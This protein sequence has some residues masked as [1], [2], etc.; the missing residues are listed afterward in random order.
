MGIKKE[1]SLGIT[2]IAIL[3]GTAV[4]SLLPYTLESWLML[5]S[6]LMAIW[7]ISVVW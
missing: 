3:F 5:S 2:Y 7:I 6:F 4:G 1:Y